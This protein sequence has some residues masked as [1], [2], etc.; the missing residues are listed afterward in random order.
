MPSENYTEG[1]K[2]A[3]LK[4]D[5]SI[6]SFIFSVLL[7]LL[8]RTETPFLILLRR[9]KKRGSK[10]LREKRKKYKRKRGTDCDECFWFLDES[11]H[12]ENLTSEQGITFLYEWTTKLLR[13]FT[14][15]QGINDLIA[16]KQQKVMGKYGNLHFWLPTKRIP[17]LSDTNVSDENNKIIFHR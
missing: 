1:E 7:F 11:E 6:Q 14:S 13:L 5:S 10:F 12:K 2:I 4:M 9:R 8:P 17:F 16:E 15:E 3:C